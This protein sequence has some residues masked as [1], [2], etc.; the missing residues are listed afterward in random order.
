M[1]EAVTVCG[2]RVTSGDLIVADS[3]GAVAIPH[4]QA[5]RAV[6]LAE[7]V[8]AREAEMLAEVRAGRPVAEVMHDSQFPDADDLL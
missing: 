5:G 6:A 3:C 1:D 4:G 8:A 7:R 2:V